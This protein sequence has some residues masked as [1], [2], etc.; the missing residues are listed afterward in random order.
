MIRN[1]QPPG[2]VK[3]LMIPQRA[4]SSSGL[5]ALGIPSPVLAAASSIIIH[6]CQVNISAK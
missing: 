4:L 5:K 2:E 3:L 1:L 6:L